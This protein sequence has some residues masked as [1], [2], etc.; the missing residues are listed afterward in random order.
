MDELDQLIARADASEHTDPV[1]GIANR[2][3]ATLELER[4][5]EL[6]ERH[7]RPLSAVRI[8]VV[9]GASDAGGRDE[10]LQSVARHLA[11]ALRLPDLPARWTE[12]GFLILLPETV[13]AGARVVAA[14]LCATAELTGSAIGAASLERRR[15]EDAAAF[16]ER[17][18][19]AG[20]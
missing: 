5:V 6:A 13:L 14:R 20:D 12:N 3:R 1:T 8:D 17:L 11:V 9:M 16:A 15:G 10:L 2:A 4:T 7:R 18:D 19:A